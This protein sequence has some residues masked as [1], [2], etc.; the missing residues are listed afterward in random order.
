VRKFSIRPPS[1]A[2]RRKAGLTVLAQPD[3]LHDQPRAV[4]QAEHA[5]QQREGDRAHAGAGEQRHAERDRAQPAQD[6]QGT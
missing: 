4:G 1:Y 6:E 3:S 2:A 5:E